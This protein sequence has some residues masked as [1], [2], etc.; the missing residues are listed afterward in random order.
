MLTLVI[1]NMLAVQNHI[2][3]ITYVLSL[4]LLGTS[5]I[6]CVNQTEL[7]VGKVKEGY[8]GKVNNRHLEK[9]Q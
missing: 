4:L 7:R 3:I 9:A 6:N 8:T 2:L 1:L 5:D